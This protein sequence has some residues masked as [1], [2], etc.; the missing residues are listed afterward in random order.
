MKAFGV[1]A[2]KK[3]RTSL[4]LPKSVIEKIAESM[5]KHGYGSKKRSKWICEALEVLVATE[6]YCDLIAEEFMDKGG[7][8]LIPVTLDEKSNG[9]LTVATDSYTH[10]YNVDVVDQSVILR[11]AIV[12]R[13]IKECGGVI[14]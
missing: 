3:Y 11:T 5:E 9:F 1:H 8:E 2:D 13:L 6:D 12:Q 10:K 7:N 4:R 14:S